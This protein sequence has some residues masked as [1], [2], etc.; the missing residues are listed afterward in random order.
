LPSEYSTTQAG[1]IYSK[2]GLPNVAGSEI[3]HIIEWKLPDQVALDQLAER[4][5]SAD[6]RQLARN[7]R[8]AKHQLEQIVSKLTKVANAFFYDRIAMST[9]GNP[10]LRVALS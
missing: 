8:K 6:L 3:Q 4:L 9:S 1:A 2:L 10:F 7:K 5:K